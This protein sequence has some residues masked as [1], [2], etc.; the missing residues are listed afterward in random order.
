MAYD[1]GVQLGKG[2]V[3]HI[4]APLDLQL[5]REQLQLLDT[6]EAEIRKTCQELAQQPISAWKAFIRKVDLKPKY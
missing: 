1:V 6:H 2:H 3:K 5:K 4:A